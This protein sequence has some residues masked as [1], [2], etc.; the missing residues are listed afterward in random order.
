[1]SFSCLFANPE[2]V[3]VVEI[4]QFVDSEHSKMEF[5]DTDTAKILDPKF[6]RMDQQISGHRMG[7]FLDSKFI[8]KINSVQVSKLWTVL[9]NRNI[10]NL[11]MLTSHINRF[12]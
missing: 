9:G 1:M 3:K 12:F 5:L 8:N 10:I 2:I 4:V 11:D 7:R 6:A